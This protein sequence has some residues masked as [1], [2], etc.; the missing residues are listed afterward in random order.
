[1]CKNTCLDAGAA[2]REALR[3]Q[4]STIQ[5]SLDAKAAAVEE[6]KARA[7]SW[8]SRSGTIAAEVERQ[9]Q[10]VERLESECCAAQLVWAMGHRC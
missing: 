7:A 2:A 6:A 1:M 3:A 8:A 5:S 9:Q 10:E 4:V